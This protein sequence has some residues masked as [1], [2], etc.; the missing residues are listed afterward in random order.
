MVQSIW[1]VQMSILYEMIFE[2]KTDLKE[3]EE[4]KIEI[5]D[6]VSVIRRDDKISCVGDILII[7][8]DNMETLIPL[9]KVL[10]VRRVERF[11]RD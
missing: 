8:R 4:I 9:E 3:N 11:R 5:N 6:G 2:I 1:G 7:I 10:R